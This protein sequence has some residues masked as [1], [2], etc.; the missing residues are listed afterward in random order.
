MA[1]S[2][3]MKAYSEGKIMGV[4]IYGHHNLG[5]VEEELI[6]HG[7]KALRLQNKTFDNACDLIEHAITYSDCKNMVL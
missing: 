2:L 1:M 6:S 7:D 4:S 5:Y 3:D